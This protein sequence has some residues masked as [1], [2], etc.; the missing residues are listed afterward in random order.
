VR[1]V[2]GYTDQLAVELLWVWGYVCYPITVLHLP[3][4][5]QSSGISTQSAHAYSPKHSRLYPQVTSLTLICVRGRVHH[6][7]TVR[8]EGMDQ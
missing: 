7:A 3:L 1:N 5:L 4:V 6:R 8:P 2:A